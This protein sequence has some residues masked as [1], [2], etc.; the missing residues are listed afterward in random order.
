MGYTVKYRK[1]REI[2]GQYLAE[3]YRE[4]SWDIAYNKDQKEYWYTE[5]DKLIAK[6][7]KWGIP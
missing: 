7:K 6:L 4:N 3:N 1:P 5:A 2:L